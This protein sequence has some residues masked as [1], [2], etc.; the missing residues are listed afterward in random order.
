[1]QENKLATVNGGSAVAVSKE[2]VID[3]L[4][5]AGLS[6]NLNDN[7][8]GMFVEICK[9]YNLNPF[10]REIYVSKY[11]S[12]FSIITG[13]EVYIK[14]AER[15]GLLDG[16][17]CVT[18][19]KG[20][21]LKATITIYRKD[22]KFPFVHEVYYPEYC[23]YTKEGNPNKFWREKPI[24]MLKKV[25]ISQGFRMCFS[26]ELGGMPYTMEEGV[27]NDVQYA[28][29]S[30]K[31]DQKDI[32]V[33]KT[34]LYNLLESPIFDAEREGILTKLHSMSSTALTK[35]IDWAKNKIQEQATI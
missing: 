3:F 34:E 2:Q 28:E 10:K 21:D 1:M 4:K 16:W 26:D 27:I 12:N 18:E 5:F 7:E 29:L 31:E 13:Y 15:S 6:G 19:G 14:R 32:E 25:A 23:Q 35:G 30:E 9:Q 17:N 33:L 24:T 20:N 11:G 8:L 22:R